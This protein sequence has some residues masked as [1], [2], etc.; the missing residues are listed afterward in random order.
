MPPGKMT[1]AYLWTA[2]LLR[3]TF[4]VTICSTWSHWFKV[5]LG[6]RRRE[7][8]LMRSPFAI[9]LEKQN[10]TKPGSHAICNS[11]TFKATKQIPNHKESNLPTSGKSLPLTRWCRAPEGVFE[12]ERTRWSCCALPASPLEKQRN[13]RHWAS[14]RFSLF[15]LGVKTTGF[16]GRAETCCA[17]V[18][19]LRFFPQLQNTLGPLSSNIAG[20]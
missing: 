4:S 11:Y 19:I 18:K 20:P 3:V 5:F 6:M 9:K 10:K 8:G 16:Q 2:P 13:A 1:L 15:F 17:F 14:V 12:S 7:A